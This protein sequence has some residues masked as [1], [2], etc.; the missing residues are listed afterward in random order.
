M[1]KLVDENLKSFGVFPQIAL[2][3]MKRISATLLLKN[4]VDTILVKR[5]TLT[6]QHW[7]IATL[8]VYRLCDRLRRNCISY[9]SKKKKKRKRRGRKRKRKKN[10]PA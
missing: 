2:I 8:S 3:I 9:F 1:L 10:P 6:C 5:S 7:E 4:L